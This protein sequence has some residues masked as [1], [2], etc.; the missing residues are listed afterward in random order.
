MMSFD[1]TGGSGNSAS[2]L[3]PFGASP[4]VATPSNNN[5]NSNAAPFVSSGMNQAPATS[6]FGAT[7]GSTPFGRQ[8]GGGSIHNQKTQTPFGVSHNVKTST[9]HQT[10]NNHVA[11]D[12]MP[13]HQHNVGMEASEDPWGEFKNGRQD[14]QGHHN[15]NVF[16]PRPNNTPKPA[17]ADMEAI[18]VRKAKLDLKIKATKKKATEI[19]RGIDLRAMNPDATPYVPSSPTPTPTPTPTLARD[20]K[21]IKAKNTTQNNHNFNPNHTSQPSSETPLETLADRNALR[22]ATVTQNRTSTS[23]LP[24]DLKPRQKHPATNTTTHT[25]KTTA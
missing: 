20:K 13:T 10:N 2:V 18:L 22:F 19:K 1:N 12:G 15:D 11:A 21:S 3:S 4:N 17:N 9:A 25:T 8:G 24:R 7:S 23:L 5:N 6:P 14:Q 16:V